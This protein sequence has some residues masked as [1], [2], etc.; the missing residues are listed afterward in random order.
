MD[1]LKDE[2]VALLSKVEDLLKPPAVEESK[3]DS[4]QS[5]VPTVETKKGASAESHGSSQYD[6]EQRAAQRD[7]TNGMLEE[8]RK[9]A[10]QENEL[11]SSFFG[12]AISMAI[13]VL[14]LSNFG[15]LVYLAQTNGEAAPQVLVAWLVSVVAEVVAIMHIIA[16][17]LFPSSNGN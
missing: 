2:D 1:A 9:K 11:R 4:G 13:F 7:H 15:I 17:Y 14:I 5:E 3:P 12:V 6:R 8:A 10:K 16:K